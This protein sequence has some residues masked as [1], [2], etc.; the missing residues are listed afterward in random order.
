MELKACMKRLKIIHS[1]CELLPPLDHSIPGVGWVWWEL[2]GVEGGRPLISQKPLWALQLGRYPCSTGLCPFPAHNTS[3]QFPH[4]LASGFLLTPVGQPA[5]RAL[6][7]DSHLKAC[8][9]LSTFLSLLDPKPHPCPFCPAGGC[10][11]QLFFN[12]FYSYLFS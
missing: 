11:Q 6:I 3:L 5:P 8:S 9:S 1:T 2:S 4:P 10:G 7:L 12:V